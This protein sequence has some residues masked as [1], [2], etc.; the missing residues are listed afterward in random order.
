[1]LA[2]AHLD[3]DA[4]SPEPRDARPADLRVRILDTDDHPAYAG[5]DERLD[6]GPGT[7]GVA[8]R[9]E[10]DIRRRALGVV[11]RQLERHDL[12][13]G[14]SGRLGSAQGDRAVALGY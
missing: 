12:G 13:V 8:A 10:G 6:A 1:M 5:G 4:R 7:P 14:A 11:T 9:L 2:G 3:L